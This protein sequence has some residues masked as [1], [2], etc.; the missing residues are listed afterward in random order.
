MTETLM[1]LSVEV[2]KDEV[3]AK[4]ATDEALMN[5]YSEEE[6]YVVANIGE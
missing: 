2:T 1:E 4:L 3:L 5:D 6:T